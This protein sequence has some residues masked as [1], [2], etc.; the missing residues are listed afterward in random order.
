MG[1]LGFLKNNTSVI[2]L[3]FVSG[4]AI[5]AA[6]TAPASACGGFWD[7]GCNLGKVVEKA[8]HDVG[9]TAEKAAQDTGHT[10]EK[11]AHD[12][13][14]IVEKAAQ[15]TGHTAEKA[16]HDTGHAIEKG[17]RTPVSPLQPS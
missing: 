11:A 1:T 8:A 15:D 14:H 7:A 6:G 10:A 2:A 4:I 16:A 13:G 17:T 5:G 9:H 3:G 12:T